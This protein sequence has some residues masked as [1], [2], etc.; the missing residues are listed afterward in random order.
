GVMCIAGTTK[1]RIYMEEYDEEIRVRTSKEVAERVLAIIASIGKV[2]FPE[3]NQRW[4]EE[5][6][7]E[8]YLTPLE[9][10]FI[11]NPNPEQQDLIDYSW[12]VEALVSLIWSLNGLD[13]MP[14]LNEQFDAW[15]NELV[16]K[17]LQKTEE[18]LTY[19]SLRNNEELEQMESYLYHQHWRVR[20]RDLGFNNDKPDKNDPN[21]NQ[22]NSGIVYE[23]RYGMSWVSG[24]GESW[25]D[26]PTDT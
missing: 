14:A 21:I 3:E 10:A 4:I 22:L 8:Q 18:F 11:Q 24:Y 17:A 23:R 25:D 19:S 26:V 9:L 12:K 15:S 6:S 20:D 5:N 7:I 16:I 2:H 13:N 1:L